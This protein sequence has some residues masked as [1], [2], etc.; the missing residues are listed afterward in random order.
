MCARAQIAVEKRRQIIRTVVDFMIESFGIKPT[1][2]QKLA[3][4]KATIILFP[5]L[6]F[7]NSQIG[8]I[9]SNRKN[10]FGFNLVMISSCLF[11]LQDLLV[12][13]DNGWLNAR[14]KNVR[15]VRN[16]LN[17]TANNST[18]NVTANTQDMENV[19]EIDDQ[20]AAKDVIHLKSFDISEFNSELFLQKLNSTRKYR[21]KMLLDKEIHLK[22]Q[23][24]YFF[25]QPQLVNCLFI[26]LKIIALKIGH[27]F[28]ILK[29]FEL[30]YPEISAFA[31]IDKWIVFGPQLRDILTSHYKVKNFKTDWFEDIERILV[32]LK[33]FPARQVGRNVIASDTTFK[34]SVNQF[35]HFEPVIQSFWEKNSF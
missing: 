5:R 7:K 26:G 24:P 16:K 15:N 3:T 9:V 29:E 28:Q 32:L 10:I 20:T 6:E 25:T 17:R 31:L 1:T 33:M 22:E 21:N 35:I 27:L 2:H 19:D 34:T 11:I 18:L 23:F 30:A 4:A 12:I 13:G 14:L 8:G